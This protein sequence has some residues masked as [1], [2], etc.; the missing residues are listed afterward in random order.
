MKAS[1][2]K[3]KAKT[4][5]DL[6]I[7]LDAKQRDKAASLLKSILADQHV[8]YLKTRNFHWNLIGPRFHSLHEFLETQYGELATVIDATAERIRMLGHVSP[9][10][11]QEFLDAATLKESSGEAIQGLDALSVLRADHET[12]TRD[13]RKAIETLSEIGDAGTE[14]FL[15]GLLQKHEQTAWMLRSYEG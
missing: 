12:V 10:S 3:S 1:S 15:T 5:E 11:M 14:D 4:T 6:R 8:L 9:G 7:G 13:L 2:T